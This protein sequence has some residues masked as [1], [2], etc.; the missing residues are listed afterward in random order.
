M[1]TTKKLAIAVVALS[2]ALVCAIGGTL[3]FLVAESEKV[4]NT[5][6]Y[7]GIEITLTE[8]KGDVNDNGEHVFGN[9]VPGA[10]VK[11]DPMVTVKENSEN[12]YVYA[13]IENNVVLNGTV[14]VKCNIDIANW[15]LIGSRT[16]DKGSVASLYQ[17]IGG[18][19]NGIVAK[20]SSDT[21]LPA[22]FEDVTFSED[23]ESGDIE[24]L[25]EITDDI[26]ITAYA[27]QADNTDVDT[28]N[29]AAIKWAEVDAVSAAI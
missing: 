7:G 22:L 5:F 25:D 29:A 11:K 21:K 23:I 13:K 4:V 9:V 12:C 15:K 16:D 19:N 28:A 8:T 27:H 2:L 6:T 1:T 3:A 24:I 17:Y 14:V 18:D 26:V 20:P 10:T